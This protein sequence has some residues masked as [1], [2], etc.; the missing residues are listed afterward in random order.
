MENGRLVRLIK[1]FGSVTGYIVALPDPASATA[2]IRE[3]AAASE[4]KVED[5][6]GVSGTLI[7]WLNLPLGR[8][9]RVSPRNPPRVVNDLHEKE[10]R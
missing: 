4:D 2:H 1:P 5:V 10:L 8:F 7:R 3:R 9:M 6:C